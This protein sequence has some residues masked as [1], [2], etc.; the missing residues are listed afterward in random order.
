MGVTR[1][2]ALSAPKRARAHPVEPPPPPRATL[3][4]ARPRGAP[5]SARGR[6][7][8]VLNHVHLRGSA[9][10]GGAAGAG[11]VAVG[12][13]GRVCGVLENSRM[14]EFERGPARV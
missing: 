13:G 2:V 9:W 6:G 7:C 3:Y 12:H 5:D 14:R 8:E 1:A 4:R 10:G 11:A